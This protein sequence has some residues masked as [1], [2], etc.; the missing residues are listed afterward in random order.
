TSHVE[1]LIP[2]SVRI[3]FYRIAQE[4]LNNVVKHARATQIRV[5]LK[6]EA[7][8]VKLIIQD[9]G[10][11][12]ESDEKRNGLGLTIMAERAEEIGADFTIDSHPDSGTCIC[13]TWGDE[14]T[15][16]ENS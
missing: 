13:V 8:L 14:E 12:L 16:R 10:G 9:N 6:G 1:T 2:P 3:A 11:G 15:E 5:I 7:N 4:A